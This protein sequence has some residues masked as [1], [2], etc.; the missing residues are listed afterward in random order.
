M[1]WIRGE[2]WQSVGAKI[3]FQKVFRRMFQAISSWLGPICID[4]FFDLWLG[5][6]RSCKVNGM[7]QS[8]VWIMLKCSLPTED[9]GSNLN[10]HGSCWG[11]S[12]HMKTRGLVLGQRQRQ[13]G[14]YGSEVEFGYISLQKCGEISPQNHLQNEWTII[15]IILLFLLVRLRSGAGMQSEWDGSEVKF[16]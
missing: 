5:Q 11:G 9:P 13:S 2:I 12:G 4:T 8:E 7:D 10:H 16:D 3:S 6:R 1:G 15:L 14:W